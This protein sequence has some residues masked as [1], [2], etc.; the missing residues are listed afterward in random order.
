MG[1]HIVFFDIDGT[2]V[3]E[4]KNVP[5]DTKIAIEKLRERNIEVAIATGRASYHL[6]HIAKQLGIDSYVGFNGS[7]V[8]HKGELI[9]ENTMNPTTLEQLHQHTL[10]YRH[11]IVYMGNIGCFTT[12]DKHPHVVDSF[13]RLKLD[14]PG[15]HPHYWKETEIY[16]AMLYCGNHEEDHYHSFSDFTFVRSD[17]L[18]LD[19]F[20]GGQTKAK[21]IKAM[22]DYLKIPASEVV[23]F[24]DGLND[25]EMLSYVGMGIA[26]G[27]AHEEVKPHAKFITKHVNEG[28]IQYGLQHLELIS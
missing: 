19:V 22:L 2:L 20:S 15:Y 7:Y 28:G 1:Y 3:N 5:D 4:E 10:D 18:Y 21:G 14:L 8:V 24:G 11:P 6:T 9:Y 17:H 12:N 27:N 25:I 13:Q 16:Q 23:A 26:M